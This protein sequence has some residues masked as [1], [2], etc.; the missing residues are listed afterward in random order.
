MNSPRNRRRGPTL[1]VLAAAALLVAGC[2]SDNAPADFSVGSMPPPAVAGIP[3]D[4]ARIDDAIA[5]LPNLAR[6]LLERSGIPGLS[7]AVVRDGKTV[8]TGGFGV[9]DIREP[10]GAVDADTVFQIASVSKAVSA[11]VVAGQVGKHEID[12]TMPIVEGIDGFTLADPYVTSHVTLADMFSHRSGLPDHAGDNLEDIGYDRQQVLARLR[13]LALD[14][15]RTQQLY[16]NFGVTAAAQAAANKAGVDW[17]SLSANTL[18]TPIGM[19][20]TSARYDDFLTRPNRAVLHAKIDGRFQPLYQRDADAQAPAGGV[21]SNVKDL[22]RWMTLLLAG[23]KYE[24]RQVIPADALLEAMTPQQSLSSGQVDFRPAA[25]GFGFNVSSE[26]SGRSIMSHSG[27]FASGAA[28][29]FVLIPSLN[30]GIVVLTNGAPVGVPEALSKEFADLAQYGRSTADWLTEYAKIMPSSEP[31][32]ALVGRKPPSNAVPARPSNAYVGAYDNDY[33][34]PLTIA[35]DG[36]TLKL[37]IGPKNQTFTLTHFDG[38]TF[39]FEPSGENANHGSVSEVRFA[40]EGD[41]ARSV[42]VE[43]WD[44]DRQGTFRRR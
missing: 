4:P 19:T 35:G 22:A 31:E 26:P 12:W 40:Y 24:G 42:W 7:V 30:V 27:A 20:S 3:A 28:T 39:T 38:D 15:F 36:A 43:F 9:K 44:E 23:G 13:Y 6:K 17:E 37:S 41:R 34:G 33:F 21:S 10:D 14:P 8:Y 2:G 18:F 16:T 11:T 5:Q 29:N 32:G 25:T 1:A